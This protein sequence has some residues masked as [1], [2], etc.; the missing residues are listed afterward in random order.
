LWFTSQPRRFG[1]FVAGFFGEQYAL[2]EAIQ[3]VRA[4]RRKSPTGQFTILSAADPLNLAGIITPGQK[5]SAL[6]TNRILYRDGLPI[7]AREGRRLLELHASAA[8]LRAE[9]S[10]RL[11]Q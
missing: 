2:P 9:V 5:I 7:A 11:P 3:R 6:A 1:S 10:A 8:D 4:V